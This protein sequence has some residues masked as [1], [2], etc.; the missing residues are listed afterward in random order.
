MAFSERDVRAVSACATTKTGRCFDWPPVKSDGEETCTS[1]VVTANLTEK[2]G[3][4]ETVS[5]DIVMLSQMSGIEDMVRVA[6]NSNC[7]IRKRN[8]KCPSVVV[9]FAVGPAIDILAP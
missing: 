2:V 8:R 7:V 3:V 4:Q 5:Q 1:L 9:S 6:R